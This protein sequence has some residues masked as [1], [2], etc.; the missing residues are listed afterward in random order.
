MHRPAH[1]IHTVLKKDMASTRNKRI[2]KISFEVWE[3]ISNSFLTLS[4]WKNE[5]L[6]PLEKILTKGRTFLKR[7]T[8]GYNAVTFSAAEMSRSDGGWKSARKHIHFIG[9]L[10]WRTRV[11]SVSVLFIPFGVLTAFYEDVRERKWIYK[12]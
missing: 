1:M 12:I 10:G 3:I 9:F 7:A 5:D 11:N 8:E 4:M 2:H 6:W